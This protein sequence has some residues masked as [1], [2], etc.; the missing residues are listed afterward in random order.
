MKK[1]V[2]NLVTCLNVTC[3]AAA[4]FL[5]MRGRVFEAG[6]LVLLA[7]VF[8]LFDG[9]LARWLGASSALGRELDSLA[10]AVSFGVAPALLAHALLLDALGEEAAG[11]WGALAY[12]PVMIPAFSIYRLASFNLDT[13]QTHAFIG[14]PTPA[15]ALFWVSLLFSRRYAPGLHEAVWGSPWV[16]S[17]CV[18]L[19]SA[20]LVSGLPMFSLKFVSFGWRANCWCYSYALLAL[21]LLLLVGVGA[22][23][24]L[25]PLYA[26]VAVAGVLVRGPGCSRRSRDGARR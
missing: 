19:F 25:V 4:V 7:M 17:G 12:L 26:G 5:A 13:R 3:G 10:D 11:W 24:F 18:V 22:V 21:L 9:L 6:A 8:D 20:L 14:M 16:L 2:P 23:S 15:H 1:H